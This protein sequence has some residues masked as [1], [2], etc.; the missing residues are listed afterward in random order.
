MK[1]HFF[2]LFRCKSAPE[3]AFS[4]NIGIILIDFVVIG[5]IKYPNSYISGFTD[6]GGK[7]G[8][9]SG[10]PKDRSCGNLPPDQYFG[11]NGCIF[12]IDWENLGLM[13]CAL[14]GYHALAAPIM[15]RSAKQLLKQGL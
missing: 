10:R 13:E 7:Y 8:A 11:A 15:T 4:N 1:T 5:P 3:V 12:G 9:D 6:L 14:L 2:C